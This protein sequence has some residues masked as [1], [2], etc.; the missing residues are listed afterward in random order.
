M[1]ELS[2]SDWDIHFYERILKRNPQDSDVVEILGSLYTRKGRIEDGLRMDRKLVRLLPDSAN[3]HY[4]LACSLAL[5]RRKADAVKALRRA[6][7][8]GYHD[9]EW[10]LEDPD[11]Q[12]LKDY[13]AF[14]RLVGEMENPF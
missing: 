7:D 8:L 13:P 1:N 14:D 4:N 6:V 9:V 5:K 11:L 10:M 12:C 3:A 2:D